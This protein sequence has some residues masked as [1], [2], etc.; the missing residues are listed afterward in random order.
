MCSSRPLQI[1][2]RP[3]REIGY[4]LVD[5]KEQVLAI[6]IDCLDDVLFFDAID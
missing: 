1:E 5:A 3:T 6:R 2:I 4:W